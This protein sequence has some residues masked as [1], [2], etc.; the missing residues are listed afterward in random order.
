M[1]ALACSAP[2]TYP[3]VTVTHTGSGLPTFADA[4][5][6][7]MAT[8]SLFPDCPRN[9]GS[10]GRVGLAV[11]SAGEKPLTNEGVAMS[12]QSEIN[13]VVRVLEEIQ[14][15]RARITDSLDECR[16]RAQRVGGALPAASRSWQRMV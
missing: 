6:R 16:F 12:I 4:D 15:R 2:S 13:S 5:H 14:H 11:H 7:A 8:A 1:A 9:C 3:R 10:A